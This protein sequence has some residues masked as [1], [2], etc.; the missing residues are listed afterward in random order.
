MQ[1]LVGSSRFSAS[2]GKLHTPVLL[3]TG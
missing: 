1:V 2:R 3:M